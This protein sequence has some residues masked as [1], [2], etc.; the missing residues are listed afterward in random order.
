MQMAPMKMTEKWPTHLR[1]GMAYSDA[2]ARAKEDVKL[3]SKR[4]RDTSNKLTPTKDQTPDSL[5]PNS[6]T[7]NVDVRSIY[8]AASAKLKR[9]RYGG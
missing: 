5:K 9:C 6:N 1:K 2:A 4:T 3:L 8:V 7:P